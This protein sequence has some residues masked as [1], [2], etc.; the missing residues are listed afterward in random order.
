MARLMSPL[1]AIGG[2]R[3]WPI[4][5]LAFRSCFLLWSGGLAASFLR[6]W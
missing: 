3:W 4:R 5:V 2:P 6:W 1:V